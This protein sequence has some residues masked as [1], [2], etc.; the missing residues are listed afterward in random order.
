M[1]EG[2]AGWVMQHRQAVLIPD[3][4]QDERWLHISGIP[5]SLA[6][7][8][9]TVPISDHTELLG[10]L[11]LTHSQRD[12]FE[13]EHLDLMRAASAQLALALRNAWMFD[14]ER[15][16]ADRQTTLYQVLRA[17]AGQ[18]SPDA[19]MEAAVEAITRFAGWSEVAIALPN[20]DRT[21]WVVRAAGGRLAAT[22]GLQHAID[23]GIIGRTLQTGQT[24]LVPDVGADEDYISGSTGVQSELS[25]PLRRGERVLGVLD[26]ESDHV[27]AFETHDVLLIELLAEAIALAMDNARLY[28]ETQQHVADLD[29][30]YTV[31][32]MTG[33]SLAMEDVL[34]RALSSVLLSLGFDAGLINLVDPSDGRLHTVA[35]HGISTALSRRLQEQG[36]EG[37]LCELV[38]RQRESLAIGDLKKEAAQDGCEP[39]SVMVAQ[40]MRAYAGIP[41]LHRD[42]SLGTMDLFSRLRRTFSTSEMTLLEAIGRQVATAVDNARLFQATV[43]E[44]QRLLTL[45]ESSR[46]GIILVGMDKRMLVVNAPALELLGL[47]GEPV[48]WIGCPL[49]QALDAVEE[50]APGAVYD[51]AAEMA[52]AR[53]GDEPPGESE[54]EV[55]PYAIHW[56]NLPVLV[57]TT[58]LGRLLVFRDVTEERMLAKM[59]D[60]LTHTMVHDL[61]NPLTGIS[62]ALQ[63]LDSKLAEVISPAQH[64]LFEIADESIQRMLELVNSILDVSQLE[65]GRMPASPAPISLEELVA[66]TVRLQSPLCVARDLE[67]RYDIPPGLPPAWADAELVSRVLQNL[68]GNAVKFTPTGGKVWVTAELC[69]DG[70]GVGE[71]AE[72]GLTPY[73][74]VSVADNGPG[75]PPELQSRLFQKFVVGEHRERGSGLG[76]AFCRLAVEAHGGRIWVESEPGKGTTMAFTLPVANEGDRVRA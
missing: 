25:V 50:Y 29:V 64:R 54:F 28:A 22:V 59:R 18:L 48:E 75:I 65:G 60:D 30:L 43:N 34:T 67:L 12:H 8:A 72:S 3:T 13:S 45:I 57:D 36:L 20:A 19:V 70:K 9:L 6:G 27:Y 24:Q 7:S 49:Q 32:R 51:I 55:A 52:R 15:D 46:D 41:L 74:R 39:A 53:L 71:R 73:L 69:S 37:M 16:M 4:H 76:L 31:T 17:V 68:V 42:A 62:V 38:H 2:L 11:T 35:E 1:E 33:Q 14:A 47:S 63:L 58:P 26:L 21:Q 40:G 5:S 61:R 23:R 66:G 56:L 44:R 10:I